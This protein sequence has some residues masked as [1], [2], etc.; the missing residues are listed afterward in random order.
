MNVNDVVSGNVAQTG[1]IDFETLRAVLSDVGRQVTELS[2]RYEG[3]RKAA[4]ARFNLFTVLLDE[5]DECRLHS[6]Y[7]A[8]LL[9]PHGRCRGAHDCGPLFLKLFL[10]I[11]SEG[12]PA[13]DGH[14]ER[15]AC[16]ETLKLPDWDYANV[17]VEIERSLGDEGRLDILI[18][19]GGWG[20]IAIENKIGAGEGDKQIGR[21]AKY[22]RDRYQRAV[23]L[24]LTKDGRAAASAG[25]F[26]DRYHRI[27]YEDHIL[28]WLEQCLR[29]TYQYANINQALQQYKNVVHQLIHGR[30]PMDEEQ[31]NE[32]VK[33]LRDC[34]MF[35][36]GE[37]WSHIKKARERLLRDCV[38]KFFAKLREEIQRGNAELKIGAWRPEGRGGRMPLAN[39]QSVAAKRGRFKFEVNVDDCWDDS[40]G[41]SCEGDVY[42]QLVPDRNGVP[43]T[44]EE[45]STFARLR[46]C[47]G[48]DFPELEAAR[49]DRPA[50]RLMV[51]CLWGTKTWDKEAVDA[52][53]KVIEYIDCTNRR[54]SEAASGLL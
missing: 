20:V 31:M 11:L 52:A 14:I 18:T 15:L 28:L 43:L 24:Y 13:H 45:S 21:Y 48:K 42:V 23:L 19:I 34:P 51:A 35:L 39:P 1:D 10:Q 3:H 37:N 27:S 38:D 47:M 41:T 22:L 50:G 25:G 7:L 6:R 17:R 46:C 30:S 12:V 40:D 54:W 8:H 29:E 5:T 9:D 53:K 16:L 36:N 4:K 49:S 33:L 44:Q 26:E 2:V 32:L